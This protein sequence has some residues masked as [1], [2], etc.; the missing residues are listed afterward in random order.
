MQVKRLLNIP[1]S[2]SFF[3]FGARGTGKSSFLRDHLDGTK[4]K[5]FDLLLPSVEER[6]F[7]DPESLLAELRILAD[8]IDTIVLDE[9]QKV[10]KLLDV[11]HYQLELPSNR[12]RFALTGSSGRKLRR[13]SANLL[14]G[15]AFVREIFPF[16]WP[17]VKD[18]FDLVHSLTWGMMPTLYNLSSIEDKRDYLQG[19]IRTYVSEEIQKELIVRN[20]DPFRK[21]LEVSAQYN[22][23][24]IN[25]SNIA[26]GIGVDAKT[27]HS[28]YSILEDTFLGHH[29]LAFDF[30]FRKK[31]LKSPKFYFFDVGV[32]RAIALQLSEVPSPS[33]SYFGEIFE[34]FVITQVLH[35][36]SYERAESKVSYYH[37]QNGVEI[38]LVI[39]RPKHSIKF[40]EIKSTTLVREDMLTTSTVVFK[41]F[42]NATFEIWSR[43]PVPKQINHVRVIPWWQ[44]LSELTF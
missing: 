12:F 39:Q 1:K 31:L 33:T 11:V 38:D 27:V 18:N 5:F 30:S 22:G 25:A 44:G 43:D 4:T 2:K 3:V 7:R 24:V 19:Y 35:I 37:D 17:E 42:P 13:G 10:P 32:C 21:F 40:I 34:Q 20:V 16:V 23:K 36:L 28:Y 6:F 15:R 9:I 26:R 41:D 29:L 14:A 8:H